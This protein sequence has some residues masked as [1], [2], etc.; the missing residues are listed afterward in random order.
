MQAAREHF[1]AA[2]P[3]LRDTGGG[4]LVRA[5][6][7]SSWA[8]CRSGDLPAG[9]ARQD[10]ALAEQLRSNPG[11]RNAIAVLRRGRGM[12]LLELSSHT[13][14][15]EQFAWS[16][17]VERTLQEPARLCKTL[18]LAIEAAGKG[19]H[20]TA[21]Q[22]Y[23]E[24]LVALM[25]EHLGANHRDLASPLV[26]LA[27]FAHRLDRTDEA[28]QALREAIRLNP[29]LQLATTSLIDMLF[30]QGRD[31]E[32]LALGEAS[33]RHRG[34]AT[35][36]RSD[37]STGTL[38]VLRALRGN[39]PE[40]HLLA[41]LPVTLMSWQIAYAGED[42]E[43]RMAPYDAVFNLVGDADVGGE[44]LAR[45][46]GF[47]SRCTVPL[48]NSPSKVRL[49]QRDAIANLLGGIE[50]LTIP[51]VI[52][53]APHACGIGRLD[54]HGL[55]LPVI[56][57]TAGRHG[58]ESV[59]LCE[60]GA[61]LR[62]ATETLR[63]NDSVYVTAYHHYASPDG[64][65][66]KYRA[67]FVDRRP[68]AYHLAISQNWLVHY[69]SADMV[70]SGWKLEEELR[71]LADM[72][73]A[74]GQRAVA[75]LGEIARRLDLDY[76]GADFALTPDGGVLLFEAN[77]TMLTHPEDETGP[78]ARKNPFITKILSAFDT[79]V[80]N[81]LSSAPVPEIRALPRTPPGAGPLD[82]QPF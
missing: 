38:L 50:G 7:G 52:R 64:Y 47:A 22:A 9:L 62:A 65:F 2:L 69:F 45:A 31:Q 53:A 21:A 36:V 8:L 56:V 63:P 40:R 57:R 46:I 16:I 70:E 68:F 27:Y 18:N 29:E 76:A 73:A 34:P 24:E 81:S 4:L 55:R 33:Y 37:G 10:E 48:L 13:D 82:R 49:T 44:A 1:E 75:V 6:A 39:V 20:W 35:E 12:A 77:A 26:N 30:R 59:T 60:T 78:L 25:R 17:D 58:G 51:R 67:I 5:L 43:A 14:A 66:R 19:G 15:L 71:F 79:M 61:M 72:E 54:A 23:Q 28:E 3:L 74:I 41:R 80:M 11:D 32:A 42:D